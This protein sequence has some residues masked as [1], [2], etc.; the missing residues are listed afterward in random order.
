[1]YS[2][3]VAFLFL[4]LTALPALAAE[5]RVLP[6]AGAANPP[7]SASTASARADA[8]DTLWI[9]T[10]DLPSSAIGEPY[11]VVFEVQGGT[12][13]FAWRVTEGELPPGLHLSLDGVLSGTIAEYGWV[14]ELYTF[15]VEVTDAAGETDETTLGIDVDTLKI[16]AVK[17][18][19]YKVNWNWDKWDRDAITLNLV[20]RLPNGFRGF[21]GSTEMAVEFGDYDAWSSD[22]NVKISSDMMVWKS[23]EGDPRFDEDGDRL[24]VPVTTFRIR[25]VPA[26]RLLFCK[27]KIRFDEGIGDD[28]GVDEDTLFLTTNHTIEVELETRDRYYVGHVTVPMAY[29]GNPIAQKGKGLIV[30]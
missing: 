8:D 28:F 9:L 20:A 17:F 3:C 1:M 5:T 15:D 11:E 2:M 29:R 23:K 10:D 26:Q 18:A 22:E 25:A 27:L 12:P 24:D 19:K 7:P 14:E 16:L 21:N 13:P 6:C 30:R 4:A